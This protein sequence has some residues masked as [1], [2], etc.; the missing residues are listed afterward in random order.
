MSNRRW[1]SVAAVALAVSACSPTT[2][3]AGVDGATSQSDV[4]CTSGWEQQWRQGIDAIVFIEPRPSEEELADV[5]SRIEGSPLVA[6]AI[7]VDQ[8]QAFAEFEARFA[9]ADEIRLPVQPED[10]PTSFR[11]VLT[12]V[13]SDDQVRAIQ[14]FLDE[15]N[16]EAGVF[17]VV[18]SL[19]HR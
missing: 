14:A 6:E 13:E 11:L 17:E 5:R 12:D 3:V 1:R 16:V 8:N 7:Y 2:T 4:V 18:D 15:L 9:D 19:C 10:I